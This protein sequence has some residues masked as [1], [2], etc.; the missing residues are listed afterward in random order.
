MG[1]SALI[2]DSFIDKVVLYEDNAALTM[3]FTDAEKGEP[4]EFSLMGG[5]F[6]LLESGRPAL[7]AGEWDAV[8]FK[9][10]I[11]ILIPR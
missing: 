1:D 7:S 11:A 8:L 5:E 6:A 2:L 10:G 4:A 3:R 9:G